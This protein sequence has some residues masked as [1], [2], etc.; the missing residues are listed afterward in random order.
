[1]SPNKIVG[2]LLGVMSGGMLFVVAP[3]TA[4]APQDIQGLMLFTDL[5]ALVGLVGAG[6]LAFGEEDR[7]D[8]ERPD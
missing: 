3:L 1:M 5:W 4:G 8:D 6:I 7:G 2:V